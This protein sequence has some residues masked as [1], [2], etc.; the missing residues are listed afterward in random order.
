MR[1]ETNDVLQMYHHDI[2]KF[3]QLTKEEE[4]EL[5]KKIQA[6]IGP[7]TQVM[8]KGRLVTVR[9]DPT[10]LES[11]H[12]LV[13]ANLKFVV[14]QA[15][16]FIGQNVPISDLISA[17]NAGMI[18]AAK[19]YAPHKNPKHDVKFITF[20]A[21]Y[22][23]KF[24]NG[25]VDETSKIV[26]IPKNQSYDIYK[27]R[28]AGEEVNT[29]TVE[30]DKPVNSDSDNTVGD[31]MLRTQADVLD[32]LDAADDRF[33]VNVMMSVLTEKELEIVKL[34]YGFTGEDDM[35]NK[36]IADTLEIPVSEVGRAMRMAYKKM[37]EKLQ[38]IED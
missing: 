9:P 35:K 10:D 34:R 36:E 3:S 20:A 38:E 21:R 19:R 15:N 28:K 33:K 29:R 1:F 4:F 16:R 23:Q 22:L 8:K 6:S 27:R 32:Q 2:D 13:N 24:L 26:R 7:E 17:G 12:M 30:I 5:A 14:K 31:I 25:E 18:E 11:L 37:R